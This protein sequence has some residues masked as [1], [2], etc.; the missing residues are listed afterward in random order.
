[1]RKYVLLAVVSVWLGPSLSASAEVSQVSLP[2][3]ELEQL[4]SA[5]EHIK[6]QYV[7]EVDEKKLL[8]DA[9][10]GMVS[11]LD[12]H[13]TLPQPGRAGRTAQGGLRPVRRH[14]ARDRDRP[15]A[16]QRH[17]PDRGRAGGSGR[18][19][20]RRRHCLDRRRRG[21]RIAHQRGGQAHARR[22][23]LDR[24]ARPGGAGQAHPARSARGAHRT[25]FGHGQ[26]AHGRARRRMDPHCRIRRR[27]RRRPGRGAEECRCS[28][29]TARPD[30]RPAQRSGRIDQ[31]G[32]RRG[33]RPLCRSTACCSRRAAGCPASIPR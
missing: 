29:R 26:A 2:R 23:G 31:R 19:R 17:R 16:D 20:D 4:F 12:P 11:G 8:T 13:S 22:T 33:N 28:G 21:G 5:Y 30:P 1:M 14:R 27:H 15:R 10:R 25:A 3:T 24:D 9:I 32:G 7:A 18:G 6:M